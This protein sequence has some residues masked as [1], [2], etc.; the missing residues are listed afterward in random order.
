M[1]NVCTQHRIFL[2]KFV[3]KD[4]GKSYKNVLTCLRI[5][6]PRWSVRFAGIRPTLTRHSNRCTEQQVE[7]SN[8]L[9]LKNK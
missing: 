8:Q 1:K 4:F 9:C 5:G 6:E 2:R 7:V 3:S